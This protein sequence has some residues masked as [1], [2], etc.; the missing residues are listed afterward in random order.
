[1]SKKCPLY[2]QQTTNFYKTS[3]KIKKICNEY[4]SFLNYIAK[5]SGIPLLPC[6]QGTFAA[7]HV[8]QDILRVEVRYF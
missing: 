6:S 1:M 3:P 5:N 2:N 7:L 8:L 4:T